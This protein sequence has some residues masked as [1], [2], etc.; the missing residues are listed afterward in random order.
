MAI[1][2]TRDSI[3]AFFIALLVGCYT[4]YYKIVQNEFFGF[5]QEWFPSV[6]ATTGDRYPARA[7]F[8]ILIALTSGPRIVLVCLWYVY[9]TACIRTSTVSFGKCLFA[10]GLMRTVACGGWVY[11]TSTDDHSIHDVSM[12]LYLLLTLPW[13]LGVLYTC[14]DTDK[15]AIKRRRLLTIAFFGTLPPMIYFFLQHKMHHV[16]GA[17]TIY[18]FF[19]WSLIIYDVAFDGITAFDF[20]RLELWITCRKRKAESV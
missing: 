10:V 20:K 3:A 6:S 19:E 2:L 7:L 5:P 15:V 16:P 12:V 18:A 17:Y 9:T 8:Q 13:Q 1:L 4:H 11:I 14:P